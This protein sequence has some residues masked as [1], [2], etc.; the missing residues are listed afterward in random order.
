MYLPAE[1]MEIGEVSAAAKDKASQDDTHREG[2]G[3]HE[4][5]SMQS[6]GCSSNWVHS[7]MFLCTGSW[8]SL[9]ERMFNQAV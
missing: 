4:I 6:V 3:A 7:Q 8:P 9:M 1:M 2:G 5:C